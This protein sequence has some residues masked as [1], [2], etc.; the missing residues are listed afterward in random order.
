MPFSDG[1]EQPDALETRELQGTAGTLDQPRDCDDCD[2]CSSASDSE[3]ESEK[4]AYELHS[5]NDKK[6]PSI[7]IAL[8][9]Q[10][11]PGVDLTHV[12]LP[13]FIL[14]PRS[15]LEKWS[16]FICYPMDL[17]CAMAEDDTKRRTLHLLSWFCSG[18]SMLPPGV[19]KPYNPV[20]G[21]TFRCYQNHNRNPFQATIHPR[22]GFDISGAVSGEHHPTVY[23][24]EQ[25][26]H[27]PPISA[28]YFSNRKAG[29]ASTG[30]IFTRSKFTGNSAGSIM[31]GRGRLYD[32]VRGQVWESTWPSAWGRGI[33]V[34]Q[35]AM[36]MSGEASCCCPD[37]GLE[38][39][40][41]FLKKP[42][43]GGERG[44]IGGEVR[45]DGRPVYTISG[46]HITHSVVTD[47]EDGQQICVYDKELDQLIDKRVA[48]V[49]AQEP[50]ESRAI[51]THV[52]NALEMEPPDYEAAQEAKIAV[53][54]EQRRIRKRAGTNVSTRY[55]TR[56]TWPDLGDRKSKVKPGHDWTYRW[57]CTGP[58]EEGGEDPDRTMNVYREI[59]EH[60]Q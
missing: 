39:K 42:L 47:L 59:R 1:M 45:V 49:A 21:E 13:T 48:P 37:L 12:T 43:F 57:I 41:K 22:F 6:V 19:R 55:F 60:V 15:L 4:H 33:F 27:H 14:E 36:E 51:W 35:Y 3:P 54:E 53:E 25:V 10:L 46:N 5:W 17:F 16:D 58:Y 50:H 44:M 56:D 7:V 29:F 8:L 28:F 24:A 32:L 11:R 2:D 18:F 40:I 26:S 30:W 20:L 38:A 9:K 23:I 52:T 31:E 34:G